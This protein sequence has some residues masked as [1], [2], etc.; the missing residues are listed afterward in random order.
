MTSRRLGASGEEKEEEEERTR[1]MIAAKL[2]D[3]D[4]VFIL[5]IFSLFFLNNVFQ[6]PTF[7][8]RGREHMRANEDDDDD[9][10]S[11]K[12]EIRRKLEHMRANEDDDDDDDDESDKAEI[13]RKL[14]RLTNACR[15]NLGPNFSSSSSS[16]ERGGG[17]YSR[18]E[19]RRIWPYK[20]SE[21]SFEKTTSLFAESAMREKPPTRKSRRGKADGKR[22]EIFPLGGG[23]EKKTEDAR[24][25]KHSYSC[26]HDLR[27]R[28]VRF[29]RD[30]FHGS[31]QKKRSRTAKIGAGVA[32][33]LNKT[34]KEKNKVLE[35]MSNATEK[36]QERVKQVRDSM[37][38]ATKKATEMEEERDR[39]RYRCE[40]L[41]IEI[42]MLRNGE[43]I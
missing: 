35:D 7:C 42:R 18:Y 21:I 9:D 27:A 32:S 11:D 20:E 37:G 1:R 4:E 2:Y 3:D 31:R 24:E 25:G 22:G 40:K 5:H 17:G 13:R 23:E 39:Y 15:S 43:R 10:E 26:E 14:E 16:S 38:M 6:S 41:E 8:K 30:G 28:R 12:A 19:L 33:E 29:R 36:N 34:R